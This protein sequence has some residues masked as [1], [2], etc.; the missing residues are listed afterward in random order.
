[1]YFLGASLMVLKA[2]MC[3][4]L[5]FPIFGLLH[6]VGMKLF[7]VFFYGIFRVMVGEIF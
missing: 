5:G 7:V 4:R 1:M 6:F 3:M 2:R